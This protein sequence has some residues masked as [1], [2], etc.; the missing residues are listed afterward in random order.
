[1]NGAGSRLRGRA[2]MGD[3]QRMLCRLGVRDQDVDLGALSC[4]DA[5]RRRDVHPGIADGGRDLRER[6]GSVL[7]VDHQ[8]ESHL[9]GGSAYPASHSG[10]SCAHT[11]PGPREQDRR[12]SPTTRRRQS[13]VGTR[14]EVLEMHELEQ[15]PD[16][17]REGLL[18][19]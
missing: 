19:L 14:S 16:G 12:R 8:V 11:P 7:H 1:M 5:G 13:L 17:R 9:S 4:P 18:D 10:L 3:R 2:E 15:A 6:A